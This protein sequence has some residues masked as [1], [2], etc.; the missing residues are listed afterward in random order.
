MAFTTDPAKNLTTSR[1]VLSGMRP[2][3]KP[4]KNSV[5]LHYETYDYGSLKYEC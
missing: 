1:R 5:S 3:G 2:T 4:L